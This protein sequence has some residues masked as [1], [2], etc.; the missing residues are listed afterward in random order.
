MRN[1]KLS[2]SLAIVVAGAIALAVAA[3]DRAGIRITGDDLARELAAAA[4]SAGATEL[5]RALLQAGP[6][7]R[8]SAPLTEGAA[9][10]LLRAAGFQ[11]TTSDPGRLLTRDKADV[12]VRQFQASLVLQGPRAGIETGRADVPGGVEACFQE[13]N[14]GQCVEC[15]KALGGGA[16][17]CAKA[18]FV[19]NK[20][21][22]GEPLP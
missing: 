22:P 10:A 21:S 2:I 7:A 14:H 13:K 9:A 4:R 16:S 11:A 20:P 8:A 18:C 6:G 17:S 3:P 12:I 1:G 5:S 19:I 15:C